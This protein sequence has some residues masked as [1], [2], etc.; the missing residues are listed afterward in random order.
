MRRTLLA[1]IPQLSP[2]LIKQQ[3][4]RSPDQEQDGHCEASV[5]SPPCRPPILAA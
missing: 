4:R 3:H 1:M 2:A 5:V